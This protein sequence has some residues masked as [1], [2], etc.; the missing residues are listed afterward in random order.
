MNN[1][2]PVMLLK[3]FV[4]LPNQEVKLELNNDVSKNV[5]SIA[6]QRTDKKLLVVCPID[7]K[8]E[9]PDVNDLPMV[10][11]S[12][13]IVSKIAL[14]NGNLRVTLKGIERVSVIEYVNND[15]YKEVLDSIITKVVIPKFD[16]AEEEAIKRKLFDLLNVYI[17]S[18]P[19]ISNS[20][21][22]RLKKCHSLFSM[23]DMITSFLPL[24]IEK[25]LG[26]MQEINAI[27]RAKKLIKDINFEIQVIKLDEKI[28]ESIN[29]ELEKSQ[30]EFILKER[31]KEIKKE[32]N[33]EDLKEEEIKELKTKLASLN[34]SE[35]I[36]LNLEREIEKYSLLSE[37][38]PEVSIIRNY[39]D[40]VLSLPW[41]TESIDEED[42][43]KI[44]ESLDKTHYALKDIKDRIIEYIAVK[45]RNPEIKSPIICLVG[46]PGVGKT[47]LAY[48]IATALNREFVKISVGGLND[49]S[50]LIGHRRTY[51]GASPGKIISSL[52]KSKTKN[53]VLLIDEVDKMVKDVKGDPASAL[54]DILDPNQNTTFIDNYVAEPFDLSKILFILTAND[55]SLI[56]DALKDR[57][58][59]IKLSGYT[60]FQ[61]LE[62]ATNYLIP[63][64][65][66]EHKITN[67]I[68]I[69]NDILKIII[70]NYTEE[71]GV[72][73]LERLLNKIIRKII[74]KSYM[75]L[76][77][78]KI[79]LKK[80]DLLEYLGQRVYDNKLIKKTN[81]IGHV[82]ALAYTTLGGKVMP[83][84]VISFD[85][86]GKINITGMLG[87][88]MKESVLVALDYIK[89][90]VSKFEIND[91]LFNKFDFHI[92]FLEG[93]IK[94]DGPSA[95]VSI[96]TALISMLI[97]KK[98]PKD[99]GLTGEISLTGEVL[100]VGGLK[101]K[102]IGAYNSNLK[103]IFIPE[104]NLADLDELD[105][106]VKNSLE[107]K[108]VKTYQ[109][110]YDLIFE[111][112]EK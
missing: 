68:K 6:Y 25:K 37:S 58:E 26:Y 64:L 28:D 8:E 45:K 54:L 79:N 10:G 51:V 40:T 27:Y 100:K 89:A 44:K 39:I 75:S 94:K 32:L 70:N 31:I 34:I 107:I 60:E 24:P 108:P 46:P 102:L 81:S 73:S 110:I 93:A 66:V 97:K 7:Q 106:R 33:E 67:E 96:V 5:I 99:I 55:E 42:L 43:N 101:E 63:K 4:I 36:Y 86:T 49:I 23:T 22:E 59:I 83:I 111:S 84:E 87:D 91:N 76:E 50:E 18:A 9:Q 80:D 104:D 103:R 61:K 109:E 85:G 29:K 92:H 16:E 47:T 56:P 77:P 41:N 72:R 3:S 53:P 15:E 14:P 78:I 48:S 95:G 57:L 1:E 30:K 65:Y 82:N 52:I 12:S 17:E 112:K 20:I 19:H 74:T 2:L 38:S 105:E 21:F 71:A 98:V 11:V 62:I 35:K 88:S 69:N 13:T 90:N